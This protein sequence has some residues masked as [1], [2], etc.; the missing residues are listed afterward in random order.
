VPWSAAPGGLRRRSRTGS[1]GGSGTGGGSA[2]FPTTP[3]APAPADP[4]PVKA[5]TGTRKTYELYSLDVRFDDERR[6]LERLDQL[7]GDDDPGI[8]YLGL[9]QDGKTAVF[10]LDEA[11][12]AQGDGTCHPSPTNCQRVHLKAGETEFFD[13]KG[14]DGS[15]AG[16]HQLDLIKVRAKRTAST[17]RAR[18][19]YAASNAVGRRALRSRMSRAGR[20]RYDART[21]TLRQL[22]PKAWRASVARAAVS[23]AV[24]SAVAAGW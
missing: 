10:L 17:S 22:S 4:A 24:S 5:P 6:T 16:Q 11:V 21:G 20:L 14:E 1:D 9:L 15:P 8:I 13:I 18:A 7:P 19:S 3:L 2:P 23:S 12:E